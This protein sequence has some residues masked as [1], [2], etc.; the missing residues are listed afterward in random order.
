MESSELSQHT[1]NQQRWFWTEIAQLTNTQGA[2]V[3]KYSSTDLDDIKN[4]GYVGMYKGT[5]IIEF[6]NF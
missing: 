4:R 1:E 6:L 2:N 5:P 3:S